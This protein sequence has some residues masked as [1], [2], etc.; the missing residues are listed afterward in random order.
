[1]IVWISDAIHVCPFEIVT[2]SSLVAVIQDVFLSNEDHLA[3]QL[4]DIE[5]GFCIPLAHTNEGYIKLMFYMLI[6][7][8]NPKKH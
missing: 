5:Y 2:T 6:V 1:M 4:T 8:V 3:F 7:S